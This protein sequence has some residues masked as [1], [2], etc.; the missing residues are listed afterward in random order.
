MSETKAGVA[1]MVDKNGKPGADQFKIVAD[2]IR[3]AADQLKA[4]LHEPVPDHNSVALNQVFAQTRVAVE[5]APS[6]R[7]SAEPPQAA[8]PKPGIAPALKNGANGSSNGASILGES[9]PIDLVSA[10]ADPSVQKLPVDLQAPNQLPGASPIIDLSGPAADSPDDRRPQGSSK[11]IIGASITLP[12]EASVGRMGEAYPERP[13]MEAIGKG[14]TK[15]HEGAA[16]SLGMYL[17]ASRE[18]HGVTREDAGRDTRIPAHYL[19]MMESNDYSMIADQLYLLPFLRRYSEYL[20]LDSEDVAIRFV[21]EVQR[22]ENSPGPTLP[23]TPVDSER[24]PSNVW[25]ILGAL[26]V[27]ALIAGWMVLHQRHHPSDDETADVSPQRSAMTNDNAG[28]PLPESI[29]ASA[30]RNMQGTMSTSGSASA[31]APLTQTPP[32]SQPPSQTRQITPSHSAN[33]AIPPP[34]GTE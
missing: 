13:V 14:A 10:V 20:G 26:A 30:Q 18:K 11:T 23:S 32:L 17:L 16:A 21:R 9:R 3:A 7:P 31:S 22:A 33:E 24:A 2:Q 19:R 6:N 5:V 4:G 27:I 25:A 28:P 15:N 34:G 1:G 12:R 29:Q 8:E